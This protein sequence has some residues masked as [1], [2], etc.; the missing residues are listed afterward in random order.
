MTLLRTNLLALLGAAI[1]WIGAPRR[2]LAQSEHDGVRATIQ[3]FAA[4]AAT[5]DVAGLAKALHPMAM[6]FVN[7]AT[8]TSL[9]RTTYLTGMTAKTMGGVPMTVEIKHIHV[10]G[11]TALAEARFVAAT[12]T[13]T[14]ALTLIKMDSG[15]VIV[16]TVVTAQRKTAPL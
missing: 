3:S 16:S 6:Q 5:R 10:S 11:A 15:W 12:F 4:G 1:L 9:D 14:H 2:A 8:L 13:L 7:G